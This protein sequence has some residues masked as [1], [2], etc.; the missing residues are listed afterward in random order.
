MAIESW[1]LNII[2]EVLKLLDD[3][4]YGGFDKNILIVIFNFLCI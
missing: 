3:S 1:R 4:N 2:Y